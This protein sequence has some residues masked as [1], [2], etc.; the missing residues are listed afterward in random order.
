MRS[1][2]RK[3]I[4]AGHDSCAPS[5]SS[6]YSE[7]SV[8]VPFNTPRSLSLSTDI[9]HT[10]TFPLADGEVTEMARL[11]RGDDDE[12]SESLSLTLCRYC[13][14]EMDANSPSVSQ[15]H[16]NG[17]LCK[18][19]LIKEVILTYGRSHHSPQCTVCQSKYTIE[20]H[21]SFGCM[22]WCRLC[23]FIE[24]C[25]LRYEQYLL[26]SFGLRVGYVLV[27]FGIALWISATA[28]V[29]SLPRPTNTEQ[30]PTFLYYMIAIFDLIVGVATL[31][32]V[33]KCRWLTACFL[34]LM[35]SA[36]CLYLL[37]GWI[38]S[39]RV[40]YDIYIERDSQINCVTYFICFSFIA[41][42]VL[43]TG[44]VIDISSQIARYRAANQKLVVHG[45]NK[46]ISI[47]IRNFNEARI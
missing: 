40:I 47:N 38:S 19:C 32:F 18:E 35:Y 30:L 39:G 12:E 42:V 16:C 28:L 14:T 4:S 23:S 9:V 26:Q 24:C 44:C 45:G 21:F 41:C 15:C 25:G 46:K 17:S 36:R 7:N 1:F 11:T 5:L 6:C 34:C 37:L 22:D 31:W 20:R 43:V 29:F 33:M 8:V 13:Y 2:S 3:T 10:E 27:V